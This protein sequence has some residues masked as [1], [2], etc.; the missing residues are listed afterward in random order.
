MPLLKTRKCITLKLV[1]QKHLTEF[2]EEENLLTI[3][4]QK[5]LQDKF[6]VENDLHD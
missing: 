2:T 1:L 4:Q 6:R 3:F 5:L